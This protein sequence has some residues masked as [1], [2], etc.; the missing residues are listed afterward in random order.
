MVG[1]DLFV[2]HNQ[3]SPLHSFICVSGRFWLPLASLA[4][5]TTNFKK[6][7]T[8][9]AEESDLPALFFTKF[10]AECHGQCS[11]FNGNACPQI[12]KVVTAQH[13]H[14]PRGHGVTN[15]LPNSRAH[16]AP[17]PHPFSIAARSTASHWF[18]LSAR[19][20]TVYILTNFTPSILE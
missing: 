14:M 12:I 11:V 17:P 9:T 19:R 8:S 3:C 4:G 16:R 1:C 18:Q 20:T 7:F 15:P 2:H 5:S 10:N 6:H 13:C